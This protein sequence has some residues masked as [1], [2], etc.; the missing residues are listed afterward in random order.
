MH[1]DHDSGTAHFKSLPEHYEKER[2]GL[3]P[4]TVRLVTRC[5]ADWLLDSAESVQVQCTEHGARDDGTARARYFTRDIDDVTEAGTI[6]GQVL[7]VVSWDKDSGA[8]YGEP[9]A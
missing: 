2:L 1:I 6:L 8:T 5:E 4:N 9:N 3:K 7:V